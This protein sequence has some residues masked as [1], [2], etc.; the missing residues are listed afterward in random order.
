MDEVKN[1]FNRGRLTLV[2]IHQAENYRKR[3]KVLVSRYAP[4]SSWQTYA[5]LGK[6]SA[7]NDLVYE[8]A[9]IVSLAST[10]TSRPV[11]S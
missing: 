9:P 5:P 1:P 4:A 7:L 2:T 3:N 8:P 6:L 11:I 10:A